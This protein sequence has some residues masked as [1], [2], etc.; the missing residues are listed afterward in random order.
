VAA[1]AEELTSS[2]QE[3]GRQIE[4]SNS[5]V[6]LAGA[7]T[8]RSEAEIEG[9]AQAAQSIS[10]VVDLIQAIAAQTNLLALNATIEAARAGE[11]GRGFA[12]VAQEVKSLAE[13]TAR[14][15]KEIA[16]HVAGIQASTSNAVAAVKE[17]AVAMRQIDEVT[18]AIASAVEQ[19]GAATREISQNVQ[20]AASGSHTLATS[21]STVND[22]IGETNRSA[23]HVL[24]AS[25]KV[26]GAAEHL[27]NEV[28]EFFVKLRNGPLDRRKE[29]DPNYAGPNRREGGG[30][31]RSGRA[32]DRKVA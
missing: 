28:Q 20:M 26:S 29:D 11:A 30:R 16:Q 21:I 27:A 15:T 6:R 19:Q 22:A 9:L 25:G 17:V 2:I 3:I 4:L 13:Q 24:D 8:A 1:A 31:S 23:D 12:V 5:T 18:T 7:T 32:R 10:S 14:A